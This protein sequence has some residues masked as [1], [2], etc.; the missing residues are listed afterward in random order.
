MSLQKIDRIA[1]W[2]LCISAAVAIVQGAKAT[3]NCENNRCWR[4]YDHFIAYNNYIRHC[5]EFTPLPYVMNSPNWWCVPGALCEADKDPVW[6]GTTN[7]RRPC[8]DFCTPACGQEWINPYY[9]QASDCPDPGPLE[10]FWPWGSCAAA[11]PP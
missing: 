4:I 7:K 9:Y 8:G 2:V 10:S 6:H 11:P 5:W 1:L 3:A